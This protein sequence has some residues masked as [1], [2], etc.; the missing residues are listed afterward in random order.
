MIVRRYPLRLVIWIQL[1]SA[2]LA[3]IGSW[4]VAAAGWRGS[5]MRTVPSRFD[6]GFAGTE[7]GEVASATP[8]HPAKWDWGWRLLVLS[9]AIQVIVG[10]WQALTL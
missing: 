7:I 4:L 2:V 1:V 9:F 10:L 8:M 3:L 5:V 6:R